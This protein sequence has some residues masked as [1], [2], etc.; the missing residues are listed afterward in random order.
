MRLTREDCKVD[1]RTAKTVE[2]HTDGDDEDNIVDATTSA[3]ISVPLH[4]TTTDTEPT[5]TQ[6]DQ[7]SFQLYETGV[8]TATCNEACKMWRHF[9]LSVNTSSSRSV[10]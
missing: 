9:G 1:T 7:S 6:S 2:G 8:L 10:E 3:T 5:V 4:L